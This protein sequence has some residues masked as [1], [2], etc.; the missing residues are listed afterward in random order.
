MHV[1]FTAVLFLALC[2]RYAVARPYTRSADAQSRYT[3]YLWSVCTVICITVAD[4]MHALNDLIVTLQKR[5]N[6]RM[7]PQPQ[8]MLGL[9]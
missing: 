2:P 9:A 4:L 3:L 6:R 1:S 7:M 8:V 5:V